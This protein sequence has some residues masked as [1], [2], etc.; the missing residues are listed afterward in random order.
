VPS[1]PASV[2]GGG[3]S[4]VMTAPGGNAV[5]DGKDGLDTVVFNGSSSA[6]TIQHGS[7][8]FSVTDAFGNHT[9]LAN[10]ERLQFND[11]SVALDID[12]TAGQAYRLYQAA[13]DRTPDKAG[14]GYWISEMDKG[15]SLMQ[16][17]QGF[18]VSK[19]FSDLY[20]ANTSD[21]QFLSAVYQNVLH[22]TPDQAGF[23]FWMHAIQIAS[24]AEVMVDFSESNENQ[25]QVIGSIQD[26]I[27]F[28]H[29]S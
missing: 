20:G 3:G 10:V 19:E 2:S 26:G 9:T 17:A 24:R 12:G 29:W 28:Q 8:G 13:F 14:L 22:R 25:A 15:E 18:A 1:T 4:D 7:A 16:V 5:V 23:D 11:Q 21:A 6:F 27:A